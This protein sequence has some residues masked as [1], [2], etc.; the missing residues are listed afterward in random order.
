MRFKLIGSIGV[1]I[2]LMALGIAPAHAATNTIA[3]G[4][5]VTLTDRILVRVPVTIVCDP[6]PNNPIQSFVAVSVEQAS[7]QTIA[8]GTGQV[9]ASPPNITCDGVTQ[10]TMVIDVLA[11]NAPFHGGGAIATASFSY[12]TGISCGVTCILSPASE[13][14]SSGA[15][16][17][18]LHA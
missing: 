9:F 3:I 16:P 15:T 10:N 13:G 11:G 18:L 1:T 7:G 2:L 6:L 5:P 14:G 17:V 4:S 8:K 12:L